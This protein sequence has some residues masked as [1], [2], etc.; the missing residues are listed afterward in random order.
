MRGLIDWKDPAWLND[1]VHY[2]CLNREGPVAFLDRYS[3]GAIMFGTEDFHVARLFSRCEQELAA[4]G[5]EIDPSTDFDQ[6]EK[7]MIAMEKRGF[8]PMLS[9]QYHDLS[10]EDAFWLFLRKKG[11]DIAGVAARLDRLGSESL[12][13]YWLRSYGRLYGLDPEEVSYLHAPLAVSDIRGKV[14]YLGEFYVYPFARG[15][16][17]LYRLFTHLLFCYCQLHWRP[18]WQY[19]FIRK[20]DVERGLASVYGYTVQVPGAQ[21]WLTP[22]RGRTS[23]E[24]LVALPSRDLVH[25]ARYHTGSPENFLGEDTLSKV[26]KFRT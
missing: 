11:K 19:A 12:G 25:T 17:N 14:A 1:G 18:D 9:S 23:N 3:A 26:E 20:K 2:S 16:R 4:R 10:K 22:V 7:R 15:S 21:T 8:T 24:Y 13:D 5:I 6:S